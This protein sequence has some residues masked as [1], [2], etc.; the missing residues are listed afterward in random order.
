M[1]LRAYTRLF[2]LTTYAVSLGYVLAPSLALASHCTIARIAIVAGSWEEMSGKKSYAVQTQDSAGAVCHASATVRLSFATGGSGTFTGQTGSAVQAWISSGSANRNFYYHYPAGSNDTITVTA[3][4]GAADSWSVSWEAS[5]NTG[6]SLSDTEDESGT[7]QSPNASDDGNGAVLT[8]TSASRKNISGTPAAPRIFQDDALEISITHPSYASVGQPV[9]FAAV[10][11]GLAE[12]ELRTVRYFWSFGDGATSTAR[13][14]SHT[15]LAPGTYVA[16]AVARRK[17]HETA[18][19]T[20]VR[21]AGLQIAIERGQ[22]G[23]LIIRNTGAGEADISQLAVTDG[24]RT[25]VLPEFTYL[26]PR[27]SILLAAAA[28]GLRANAPEVSAYDRL[29]TLLARHGAGDTNALS[30]ALAVSAKSAVIVP[31]KTPAAPVRPAQDG[32]GNTGTTAGD[33]F[34]A[35]E[36]EPDMVPAVIPIEAPSDTQPA[37]AGASGGMPGAGWASLGLSGVI[38]IGIAALYIHKVV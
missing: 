4:Y 30:P 2:F 24:K 31:S 23:G 34:P 13:T 26:L 36:P 12:E 38:A 29:G 22:D 33:I 6:D 20:E 1:V 25:F 18:V 17:G 14:P 5:V 15:Y 11:R 3:G 32:G 16:V 10:P 19:R 8:E 37:A 27:G 28:T 35:E 7:M 9:Q 21:V